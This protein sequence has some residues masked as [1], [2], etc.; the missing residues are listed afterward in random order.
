MLQGKLQL[1]ED[2]LREMESVL[3]A[4]SGGVDST[5]LLYT[6][7]R[8]LEEKKLRRLLAVTIKAPM[9]PD[10]E[11]KEA[12][13]YARSLGVE[14]ILLEFDIMEMP[15]FVA[16]PPRR[17]YYCKRAL[18]EEL[19]DLAA[20]R[21]LRYVID[22]SNKD[23]EGDYRPGRE[24]LKEL[25]IRSPL[26]EAGLTKAEIRE[27]SRSL[28]LPT[29]DK[30]SYACL[31]SRIPYG[32]EITADKLKLIDRAE[33]YLRELGFRQVRVRYHH[34]LARIEVETG[35]LKRLVDHGPQIVEHLKKLGFLYV[36]ADLAG[37]RTGSLNASL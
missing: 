22:G 32:V 16:N 20:E 19:L 15:E 6:A 17:C 4:F 36:T 37:Y 26:W 35:E 5:F 3:V 11:L 21:G 8:L 14:H 7:A 33:E 25:G 12:E 13:E 28:V 23:D 1:L 29:W 10:W 34:E 18:F 31:A 9:C 27:A 2:I 24:A 30:P